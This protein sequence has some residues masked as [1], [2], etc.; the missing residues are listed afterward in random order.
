MTLTE[1]QEDLRNGMTIHDAL[2]KHELT[3]KQACQ[4]LH[5]YCRP[6]QPVHKQSLPMYISR[7]NKGFEI[8]KS[9]NGKNKYF[10]TYKTLDDAVLMRNY[11]IEHGWYKNRVPAIREELGI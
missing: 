10:G 3:F 8:K 2:I 5:G 11:L 6:K 9:V 4:Y 1:F 7:N